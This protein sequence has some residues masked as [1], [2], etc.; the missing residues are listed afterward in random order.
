MLRPNTT[1]QSRTGT[2][3]ASGRAMPPLPG[4][5][6]R[7]RSRV[8]QPPRAASG[9]HTR[10]ARCVAQD[11][12]CAAPARWHRKAAEQ[13]GP[14]ATSGPCSPRDAACHETCCARLQSGFVPVALSSLAGARLV[15][16]TVLLLKRGSHTRVRHD[17]ARFCGSLPPCKVGFISDVGRGRRRARGGRGRGGLCCR[18]R[19]RVS[20]WRGFVGGSDHER[21]RSSRQRANNV[22][23]GRVLLCANAS[24]PRA[25]RRTACSNPWREIGPLKQGFC[26]RA[27]PRRA[28]GSAPEHAAP[29]RR[30]CRRP[31]RSFCRTHRR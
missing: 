11:H 8:A 6:G 4:G 16:H 28:R 3:R 30:S 1:L 9:A 7:V 29:H 17:H 5:P 24:R 13:G 31:R 25:R 18:A 27:C 22:A 23:T 20:L 2:A 15:W 10:A 21:A 26:A 12:A 14:S 19:R